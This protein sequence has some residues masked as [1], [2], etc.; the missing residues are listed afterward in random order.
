[1]IAGGL[2]T[3]VYYAGQGGFDTHAEPAQRPHSLMT[4]LNA[5][6]SAFVADL[7]EQGNF[8]RGESS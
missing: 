4:D 6:L 8:N 3:R 2:P 1:M 7:K 5:S